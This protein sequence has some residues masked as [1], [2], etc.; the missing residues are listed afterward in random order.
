MS[1]N[2]FVFPKV[3]KSET[4][5]VPAQGTQ[6]QNKMFDL[7]FDATRGKAIIYWTSIVCCRRAIYDFDISTGLFS[8]LCKVSLYELYLHILHSKRS[9]G[10]LACLGSLPTAGHPDEHNHILSQTRFKFVGTRIEIPWKMGY[11]DSFQFFY[12]SSWD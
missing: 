4:E 9:D 10:N 1:W 11:V 6:T 12:H 7:P 8:C 3:L 5:K 2:L